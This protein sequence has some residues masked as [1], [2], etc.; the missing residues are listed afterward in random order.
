MALMLF[1]G[2]CQKGPTRPPPPQEQYLFHTITYPGETLGVIA[3]WY[4]GTAQNWMLIRDANPD[5]DPARLRLGSVVRVP[6]R[7]VIKDTPLPK[8][9]IGGAKAKA[10]DPSLAPSQPR[11]E[12][13]SEQPTIIPPPDLN[14]APEPTAP[15]VFDEIPAEPEAAPP[16]PVVP[17]ATIA[18]I[19]NSQSSAKPVEEGRVKSRDE[20][21]K[22]LLEDY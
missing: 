18:P 22:E 4:T 2:A 9:A 21:L 14:P 13:P 20:L 3:A 5:L 1:L 15:P 17:E 12:V 8:S 19:N 10:Q 16:V 6:R 11:P 7:L